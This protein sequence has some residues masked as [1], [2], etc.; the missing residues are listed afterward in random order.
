MEVIDI[1]N[2]SAPPI[3]GWLSRPVIDTRS[4]EQTVTEILEAVRRDGDKAV[5]KYSLLFDKAA[6]DRAELNAEEIIA[7]ARGGGGAEGGY[8]GGL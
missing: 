5:K 3:G 6:P 8:Q 1:I 2:S 4:L 7:G